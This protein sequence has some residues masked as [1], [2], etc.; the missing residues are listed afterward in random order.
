M[1]SVDNRDSRQ[2]D[3]TTLYKLLTTIHIIVIFIKNTN[4]QNRLELISK[5]KLKI[6]YK[7]K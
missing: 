3:W 5:I 2:P 7:N 1:I 6:T 4:I